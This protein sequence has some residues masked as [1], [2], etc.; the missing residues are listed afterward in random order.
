M[1]KYFSASDFYKSIFGCKVYKISLD[2][3]CTCPTR[4]GTLGT[5]GCIFCSA[6]GSGE[7]AACRDKSI[8]EQ[9][10]E[11]K[12][13]VEKKAFGRRCKFFAEGTG[14][15]T[16]KTNEKTSNC[17][18]NS[19]AG[20]VTSNNTSLKN[21][22]GSLE[23]QLQ[24]PHPKYIAYF[25]NFTNTYGDEDSLI[26]K[27]EE[28]L[29]Q[30]DIVGIS[31]ATRPDCIS[32]RMLN[33]LV[34]LSRRTFLQ[35]ELGLQ[36]TKESSIK[37]IRRGY[38]NK[39]YDDIVRKL[40]DSSI[41]EAYSGME[42]CQ[43][44]RLWQTPK[45][46]EGYRAAER[47]CFK[48]DNPENIKKTGLHV[49]TQIIFGLPGENSDD[50]ME[51][52]KHAVGAGTDG[53]KI[54]VLYVL[55]GTDLAAD[56]DAKKFTCLSEEEYFKLIAQAVELLPQNVV[57]HRLTGD[58][59][60]NLLIAPLWTANKRVVLNNMENYFTKYGVFQSKKIHQ[61]FSKTLSSI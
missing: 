13:L 4:D 36:T 35:I 26:A 50:M 8:S 21:T 17:L 48:E 41:K 9:I 12:A 1:K 27:Y 24:T 6:G 3:G 56:F 44:R 55:R 29:E 38:E 43:N 60:K 47:R 16:N 54:T 2:A 34:D 10:K 45:V 58:G 18:E 15:S 51:S 57:V 5:K 20:T 25:Q 11:A 19:I 31:I 33:Y 37:Y 7:F 59:P 40:K 53:V 49:V 39:V 30:D 61:N 42:Q 23:Q 14:T 22:C 52:V 32:E 46:A 28:A